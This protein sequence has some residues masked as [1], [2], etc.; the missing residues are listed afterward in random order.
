MAL[1]FR[2]LRLASCEAMSLAFSFMSGIGKLNAGYASALTS[3]F[4]L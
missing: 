2:N 1:Y 3:G 4:G